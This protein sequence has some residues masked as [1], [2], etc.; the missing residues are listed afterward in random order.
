MG[1]GGVITH[2]NKASCDWECVCI[3]RKGTINRPYFMNKPFWSVDTLFYSK[4]F[5]DNMP[6]FQYFL[7]QN[8]NWQL[9]NEASGVPSLSASTIENIR[10]NVPCLEEQQKIV[11]Y[12]QKILLLLV[13][14]VAIRTAGCKRIFTDKF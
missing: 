7:F 4:P 3:G 5:G 13:S 2:V 14:T 8:I 6:K 1:T 11:T 9:Y 12:I 10:I